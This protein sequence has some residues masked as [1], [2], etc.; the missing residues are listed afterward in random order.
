MKPPTISVIRIVYGDDEAN[1]LELI[2]FLDNTIKRRIVLMPENISTAS[3]S[4][5]FS[6]NIF[7]SNR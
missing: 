1:M 5:Y 7:N 2:L 3:T 6:K 4:S